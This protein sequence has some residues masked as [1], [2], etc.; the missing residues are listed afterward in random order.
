MTIERIP[1]VNRA[2][3]LARRKFDV[4]A[5]KVGAIFGLDPYTS[6]L[7]LYIEKQGII[8]LPEPTESGP[9]RRG[10]ILESAVAA[11]VADER[12]NWRI[13]KA[14]DYFRDDELGLAATPD[15]FIHGLAAL[16][17]RSRRASCA[18]LPIQK[19]CWVSASA[20]SGSAARST[21]RREPS[22]TRRRY[23]G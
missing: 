16:T 3:W 12:P 21:P 7:R 8:D 10:R 18:R 5:S 9:M 17:A 6:S 15:F 14:T 13:E 4:T 20:Y 23:T 11:A 19:R 2:E 1:I 22:R